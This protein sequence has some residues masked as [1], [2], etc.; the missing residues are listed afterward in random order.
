MTGGRGPRPFAL[1]PLGLLTQKKKRIHNFPVKTV[2]VPNTENFNCVCLRIVL[3][4]LDETPTIALNKHRAVLS[5]Q[6]RFFFRT[7]LLS[8]LYCCY[9]KNALKVEFFSLSPSMSQRQS[10][11]GNCQNL[12]YRVKYLRKYVRDVTRARFERK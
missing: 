4:C 1:P 2:H 7:F 12:K 5:Q 3:S 11:V 6:Y 9:F 10:K 8:Y